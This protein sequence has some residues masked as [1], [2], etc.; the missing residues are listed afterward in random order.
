MTIPAVSNDDDSDKFIF[1]FKFTQ[2]FL[3]NVDFTTLLTFP[4]T[5]FNM[6][7]KQLLNFNYLSI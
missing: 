5:T 6:L 1:F 2:E 3:N 4:Q 7:I